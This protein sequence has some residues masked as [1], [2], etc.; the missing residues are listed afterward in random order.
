[1]LYII[2]VIV[3]IALS[4]IEYSV[5]IECVCSYLPQ[6]TE[7]RF[8]AAISKFNAPFLNPL[9]R[10][11]NKIAPGLPVDISPILLVIIAGIIRRLI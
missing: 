6:L 2:A 1:M 4:L 7:S 9:R 3:N 5:I 8:Y 11:A 10:L